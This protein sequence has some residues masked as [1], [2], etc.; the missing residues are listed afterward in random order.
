ML[1]KRK[2]GVSSWIGC[3]ILVLAMIVQVRPTIGRP[4][5][6]VNTVESPSVGAPAAETRDIGDG[7]L[8][9]AS[10]TGALTYSYNFV[11]PPGRMGVEPS[12]SLSYSSQGSLRG[13]VASN[14]S[15]NMPMIQRDTSEGTLGAAVGAVDHDDLPFVSS[16][17]GGHRLVPTVEPA[18]SGWAAYRAEYDDQYIRYERHIGS[19]MWRARTLDG[20]T[21]YFGLGHA[22]EDLTVDFPAVG[23]LMSHF[24]DGIPARFRLPHHVADRQPLTRMV[25]RFGNT[26]R[27]FWDVEIDP[28]SGL[29]EELRLARIRYSDNHGAGIGSHARVEFRYGDPNYCGGTPANRS[30][31][32]GASVEYRSGRPWYRGRRTL[33]GVETFVRDVQ[34]GAEHIVR[35]V[36]LGVTSSCPEN[37][38]S[39]RTLDSIT[40]TNPHSAYETAAP[41]SPAITFEYGDPERKFDRPTKD[42]NT[43]FSTDDGVPGPT[44]SWGRTHGYT[45]G[46]QVTDQRAEAT[47]EQTLLD[48]DGDGRLDLLRSAPNGQCSF[49]FY[50]ND[51]SAMVQPSRI[52]FPDEGIWFTGD[53]GGITDVTVPA[54]GEGCSLSGRRTLWSNISP[55]ACS[56]PG[57]QYGTYLDHRFIDM[58]R[59]GLPD[60]VTTK[61]IDGQRIN[62]ALAD[63]SGYGIPG[64]STVLGV[65]PIGPNETMPDVPLTGRCKDL[66]GID[67]GGPATSLVPACPSG[68]N[69]AE[70][71][72]ADMSLLQIDLDGLDGYTCGTFQSLTAEEYSSNAGGCSKKS[73]LALERQGHFPWMIY[74]NTGG[75]LDFENPQRVWSPVPLD[76]PAAESSVGSTNGRGISSSKHSILDITGDGI[77]DAIVTSNNIGFGHWFVFPGTIDP[78]TGKFSDFSRDPV[79]WTI[80][81]QAVMGGSGSE[82]DQYLDGME[83]V[84]NAQT[85]GSGQLIDMNADGLPD[86]LHTA[87]GGG[88]EVALNMGS[89]FCAFDGELGADA[90]VEPDSNYVSRTGYDNTVFDCMEVD[91]KRECSTEGNIAGDGQSLSKVVDID[92]D[93]LPDFYDAWD[94]AGGIHAL[95]SS[96]LVK[97][98]AGGGGFEATASE[99]A[100]L[101]P[102]SVQVRSL[103]AYWAVLSDYLDLD[104]DGLEDIV[105]ANGALLN[106]HSEDT[107]LGQP[108]RLLRMIDNGQGLVTSVRYQPYND[109]SVA[110]NPVFQA[111]MPSHIWVVENVTTSSRIADSSFRNTPDNIVEIRYGNP[112]Y[113][114]DHL[115]RYGFRGFTSIVTSSPHAISA[116]S[117]FSVTEEKWDYGMDWSG[118]H[119]RSTTYVDGFPS[120]DGSDQTASIST[121]TWQEFF[122]AG[123]N[124][125]SY[126]EAQSETRNCGT[127]SGSFTTRTGCAANDPT[128]RSVADHRPIGRYLDSSGPDLAI[129]NYQTWAT[130]AGFGSNE[131]GA[132]LTRWNRQLRSEDDR[133]FVLLT[134]ETQ[135]ESDGANYNIVGINKARNIDP[136]GLFWNR[137]RLH[138]EESIETASYSQI[139]RDVATGQMTSS[140]SP[141]QFSGFDQ[142][143]AGL[144]TEFSYSGFKITARS[145][146][147]ALGHTS[148][149]HVDLGTG[150]IKEFRGANLLS[151]DAAQFLGG[152]IEY[153]LLGRPL[154]TY[155]IGCTDSAYDPDRL[156]STIEYVDFDGSTPAHIVTTRIIDD[157]TSTESVVYLDGV[158]RILRTVVDPQGENVV[159]DFHYNARGQLERFLGP[160]PSAPAGTPIFVD[161]SYE[162]DS[163]G[164]GTGNRQG[165]STT[166]APTPGT[167]RATWDSFVGNNLAYAFDG[168][169]DIQTSTEHVNDTSAGG[170][171]GETEV[172]TDIFGRMTSV[173]ELLSGGDYA[174]TFYEFDGNDNT[175]RITD[176]DNIVTEMTH[177]WASR[178]T[179]VVRGERIWTYAYDANGNLAMQ[180][181]PNDVGES[182]S[183]PGNGLYTSS[184]V[185][186]ALDRPTSRLLPSRGLS[187]APEDNELDDF[188]AEFVAFEYDSCPSGIGQLCKVYSGDNL[189]TTFVFDYAQRIV[190]KTDTISLPEGVL[191]FGDIDSLPDFS[192][193]RTSYRQYNVS[194]AVAELW[195]ADGID[196]DSSTH[197]T[198]DFD[199]VSGAQQSLTWDGFTIGVRRNHSQRIVEQV[200]G[201]LTRNWTYDY[202]GRVERT[203]VVAGTGVGSGFGAVSCANING[204][205]LSEEMTY[206]D[207]SEVATHDVF[208][209]GIPAERKFEY[210]YDR[211]HQLTLAQNG[212][213]SSLL[214]YQVGFEYSPAGRV[215]SVG[216]HGDSE[217]LG[218]EPM[219]YLGGYGD[220]TLLGGDMHAPV[221]LQGDVKDISYGYDFSGNVTY[222]DETTGQGKK[223][224]VFQYDGSDQQREV[225]EDKDKDKK[226]DKGARELYYYDSLGA[227]YMAV[228][229]KDAKREVPIRIRL[230]LGGAEIWFEPDFRQDE[231]VATAAYAHLPLGGLRVARVKTEGGTTTAE[232]SFHNGLGHL[233]GAVDWASGDVSA[234]FVYGPYGEILDSSGGELDTHLRRFNGK[235][236]DQLSQLSYYGFRYYDAM[237]LSWT[238]ADPL[239]R[240]LPDLAG[241]NPREM[242]LYS[243]SLNNP[244]RYADPD[245][246]KPK[247]AGT[248]GDFIN[249]AGP[250][251]ACGTRASTR[252]CKKKKK[253]KRQPKGRRGESGDEDGEDKDIESAADGSP[254]GETELV[255]VVIFEG[256]W[257]F[258][259]SYT[260]EVK[261]DTAKAIDGAG[262]VATALTGLAGLGKRV[263][264]KLRRKFF[265]K[266]KKRVGKTS[267]VGEKMPSGRI[268]GTGP[269]T[270][271]APTLPSN[272]RSTSSFSEASQHLS[273][274][275]GIDPKLASERLHQIKQSTGRGGADNVI[276]DRTGGV[277][278]PNTRLWLG[279]LT[280]GGAKPL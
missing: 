33:S 3:S 251:N 6:I 158:G 84:T 21:W 188:D 59:D 26:V 20:N 55:D 220:G 194:G 86:L 193:S 227:R 13:G 162:Y 145:K 150:V 94:V 263:A 157:H 175:S 108:Q 101:L 269:G 202:L 80:P 278:D 16:M 199:D 195:L 68:D 61:R 165:T 91:A 35:R 133:Y 272:A 138:N 47:L 120:G 129:V 273:K 113:N 79:W 259:P 140:Q 189:T 4:G 261:P 11:V 78:A 230:W 1:R 238:Q 100:A 249:A 271:H 116:S 136:S 212:R 69:C 121:S 201:C 161:V 233:M 10:S 2:R 75:N 262:I 103:G 49:D 70:C 64:I 173:R 252:V 105:T 200:G 15:M 264:N 260:I 43:R 248:D 185:Y 210:G 149:T 102:R 218:R 39:N 146:T 172:Y 171:S 163:L 166:A 141:N 197:L 250:E 14:W 62:T 45:F 169:S 216:D 256:V 217:I 206:F 178:R 41:L 23:P 214:D 246:R 110:V 50:R 37:G 12:L 228:T 88:L 76:P 82:N 255:R 81:D 231:M 183:A 257:G 28:D 167:S 119:I 52:D 148:S 74:Y 77:I 208:R 267:R 134:Q 24:D 245:G 229:F 114:K 58:N 139:E 190:E 276:F 226:K 87:P 93:G 54:V 60:L 236:A 265:K 174:E 184:T 143:G 56:G 17:S 90:I 124:S 223:R 235:E 130:G 7:D 232:A 22:D 92:G 213:D 34:N 192:V 179:E 137:E 274:N 177:D 277:Y 83:V 5:N 38:G 225:R 27:Y 106:L 254:E 205:V 73:S 258:I 19:G 240:I 115:G 279:S 203:A 25:D 221:F 160:D 72:Y 48:F 32:A 275:H 65:D 85:F 46:G 97:M 280:E 36:Q 111:G 71:T 168:I 142:N 128:T 253:R 222:R 266:A 144:K 152:R 153:D 42:F 118:R 122:V 215:L 234:A 198:Y 154:R 112:E 135:Y 89:G 151:C 180:T 131:P 241:A 204:P 132:K 30:V 239:Y 176:A 186:D 170:P 244:I 126:V 224:F 51:G 219:S 196:K 164:R 67:G 9:Y 96:A 109:S 209:A 66:F 63:G 99:M 182:A 104:G 44:V 156:L 270:P 237:S 107:S 57:A 268:A 29:A 8:S 159:T 95:A 242:A 147:N 98:S 31:P 207:S 40:V 211:Q 123:G 181:S 191:S 53:T 117:G 187:S 18:E 243:F 155:E 125:I 127:A 247:K